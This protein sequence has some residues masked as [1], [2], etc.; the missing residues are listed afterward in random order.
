MTR[1]GQ[2]R[3][4]LGLGAQKA[5]STWA[6]TYLQADPGVDLGPLKEYH[7]WDVLHLSE[8]ASFDHRGRSALRNG[9]E[10]KLRR[11]LGKAPSVE[12]VR[13]RLQDDIEGYFDF[14][15]GLLDQP[16]V[17]LTG[18]ITPAYAGLPVSVLERIRDGFARRG[19]SVQA[20]FLMRDP[21]AR[22]ISAAQMN[23]R[24]G[25]RTE[26]VPQKGD[27]DAAVLAYVGTPE[28][29][30]RA[31]YPRSIAALR[32]VL[33]EENIFFGFYETLFK[34][35]CL[36]RLSSFAGIGLRLDLAKR[37][38]NAH[39]KTESVRP[40]TRSLLR[41]RLADVYD[42]CAEAFPETRAIWMPEPS[43]PNLPQ[44]Q[45]AAQ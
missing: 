30:L 41:Q 11:I 21:V 3:F 5:G 16:G 34:A 15:A 33:T 44:S 26:A 28:E 38:V 1:V 17:H 36:K 9:A 42:G 6:Y 31:D 10:A 27:L 19:I 35:E 29:R 7:V 13:G 23:R 12:E 2:K 43:S 20:M 25:L 39:A 22:C 18:D 4:L 37:R 14:F 40:E 8:M 24:K 45:E 32:Q